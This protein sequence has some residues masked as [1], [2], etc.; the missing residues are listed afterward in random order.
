MDDRFQ[1]QQATAMNLNVTS[2]PQVAVE[3]AGFWIRFVAAF[4]DN[5][6]VGVVQLPIKIPLMIVSGVSSA[7]G[8]LG[9]SIVTSL[10]S[11]VL[12]FVCTFFYYGYFYSKKGATPGKMVV[13]LRVLRE[14]TGTHLSYW[15]SFGREFVGKAVLGTVTLLVG[16][17]MAAFREDKKAL[18]DLAFG[19]RVVKIKK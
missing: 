19:S 10:I 3:P 16:Y 13:G 18:H 5:I 8:E 1:T 4:L 6:I 15:R 11:I 9:G 2:A 7:N 17:L 12:Y 14:D